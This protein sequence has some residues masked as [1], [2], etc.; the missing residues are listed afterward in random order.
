MSR[1]SLLPIA[2][3]AL[4][5]CTDHPSTASFAWEGRLDDDAWVRIRN[6][7][8]R[9]EVRR[10]PDA[11]VIVGADVKTGG[12]QV[13]WVRDSADDGITFCVVYG[14]QRASGCGN[15]GSRG[16]GGLVAWVRKLV[17]GEGPGQAST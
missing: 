1:Y 7:N 8:G 16:S 4:A 3:L 15:L 9:V 6:T 5:G 17:T 14:T 2:L 10:S 11:R 13:T 12:Q